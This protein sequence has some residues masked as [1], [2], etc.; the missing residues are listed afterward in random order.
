VSRIGTVGLLRRAKQANLID[1]LKPHLEA[2]QQ[3]GIYIRQELVDAVLRDVG[4]MT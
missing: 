1:K 3:G 2:L 4:E